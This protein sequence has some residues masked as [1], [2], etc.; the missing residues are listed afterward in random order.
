MSAAGIGTPYWYEWEI[1][2]FKCVEMLWN[3]DIKSVIFQ[4]SEFDSID[5][6]VVNYNNGSTLNMKTI[7]TTNILTNL[8]VCVMMCYNNYINI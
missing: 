6:V 5:D 7:Y 2:L 8:E 4:A 3:K 1:G